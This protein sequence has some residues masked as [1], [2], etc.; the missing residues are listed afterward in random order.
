MQK[1]EWI[2]S[3]LESASGIKEVEA[4]PYLY[5]KIINKV[6]SAKGSSIPGPHYKLNWAIAISLLIV[7]NASAVVIYR[8]DVRRQKKAAALEELSKEM[9]SNTTYNY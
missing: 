9:T 4:S 1:E 5:S 2:N 3:I 6:S 7:L 8:S